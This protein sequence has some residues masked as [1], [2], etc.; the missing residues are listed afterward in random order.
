MYKVLLLVT[1]F[2]LSA[3]AHKNGEIFRHVASENEMEEMVKEKNDFNNKIKNDFKLGQEW[4]KNSHDIA[5]RFTKRNIDSAHGQITFHSTPEAFNDAHYEIITDGLLDDSTEGVQVVLSM[6]KTA[7]GYWQ[8]V[9]AT[10]AWKCV[11]SDDKQF[12]KQAC[13]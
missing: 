8:I 4:P 10:R 1:I 7:T 6:T 13:Q 5:I 2:L 11:R 12:N 9:S 3:C